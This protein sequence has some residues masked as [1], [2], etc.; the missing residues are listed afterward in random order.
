MSVSFLSV[1]RS[2]VGNAPMVR[3]WVSIPHAR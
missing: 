3:G 1:K 2:D